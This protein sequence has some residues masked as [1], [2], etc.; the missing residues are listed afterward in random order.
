MTTNT[1]KILKKA[2]VIGTIS[3]LIGAVNLV[4]L[5]VLLSR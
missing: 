1:E 4:L 3:I 2:V 5:A